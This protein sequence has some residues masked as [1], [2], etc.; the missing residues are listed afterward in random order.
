LKIS[1]KPIVVISAVNLTEGGPLS[2]LIDAVAAFNANYITQYN[3]VLLIQNKDLL[4]NLK[5][6]PDIL[7]YEYTYPKRSW[8][9]RLWFE[10]IHSWFI[11]KKIS[12][13]IWLSLHDITSNV[14]CKK[15][16]VYCHNPAP[17]YRLSLRD[18]LIEKSLLFFNL[19]Y[20][21]FY[22]VNIRK[23][24]FV[25]VQQQWMREEFERRY[26]AKNIIVSYPDV[27][28]QSSN[29]TSGKGINTK[30]CFFYPSLP[31][32][33]KNFEVLLNAAEVLE[34]LNY[35]FEVLLTF[36][37]FENRYASLL[38]KKY[39]HLSCIKFSGLQKRDEMANLYN[40]A[41]CVVF[42]SKME[43]WGLPITEAKCYNKPVLVANCRYAHETI[44][45]YDKACFFEADDHIALAALM[46][47]AIT[48]TLKY[49]VPD[50]KEPPQP[51]V[52]SWKELFELILAD[53]VTHSDKSKFQLTTFNDA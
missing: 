1:I 29:T 46:E 51:F 42:A 37:G 24:K 4:N 34:K 32:V 5:L 26:R 3:L 23:N 13:H 20:S 48:G 45:N 27:Q 8:L 38:K 28:T 50:Y 30:F 31:R 11:S 14:D 33:F 22:R 15:R 19:F 47:Q 25:I 40:T 35:H 44:G 17:F 18:V 43:T 49:N 21:L 12:P 7:I 36:D 52:Q 6:H 10:Y 53:E 9:L 16:I 39:A 41:A 2:I